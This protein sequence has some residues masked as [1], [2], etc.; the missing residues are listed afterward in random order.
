[1]QGRRIILSVFSFCCAFIYA[2]EVLSRNKV[3]TIP[4]HKHFHETVSLTK[5]SP[6]QDGFYFQS[7]ELSESVI[8]GSTGNGSEIN[9]SS[10]DFVPFL[11][12]FYNDNLIQEIEGKED[13]PTKQWMASL[14]ILVPASG[15]YKLVVTSKTKGAT[16]RFRL[17]YDPL[18][19]LTF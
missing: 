13:Y 17:E 14:S 15:A 7:Y 1:M 4:S 11:K 19:D 5:K 3:A 10:H 9:V 18:P 6:H 8:G 16:G 12:L 2:Q